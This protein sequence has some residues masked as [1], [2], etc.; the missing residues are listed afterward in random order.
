MQRQPLLVE[1]KQQA[2]LL[3]SVHNYTP[4]MVSGNDKKADNIIYPRQTR[5]NRNKYVTAL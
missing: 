5:I 4:L 1:Y 3:L 2:N